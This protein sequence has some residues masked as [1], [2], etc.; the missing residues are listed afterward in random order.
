MVTPGRTRTE[1]HKGH[2]G[3]PHGHGCPRGAT[4]RTDTRG[5]PV[6]GSPPAYVVDLSAPCPPPPAGAPMSDPSADGAGNIGPRPAAPEARGVRL[7]V[8]LLSLTV[9]SGL[10]DAV[11]YLRLGHVFTAN[12][13]GN[14]VVLGFAAAGAPGFSIPHTLTSLCCFVAGATAGGRTTVRLSDGPRRAWARAV[15][16]AEAILTAACA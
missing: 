16:G 4:H 5:A 1:G 10:I 6:S 3:G 14:V 15:F 8:V 2:R 13:T 9:V 11:T 7:V 12:M